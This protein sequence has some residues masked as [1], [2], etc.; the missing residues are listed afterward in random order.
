VTFSDKRVVDLVSER[1]IPVWE[2]VAPVSV[3]VFDL[4]DGRTVK[5]TMGGE[6][7]LYFCRPDGKVFDILPALHSPHVT[8]WA[9]KNALEFYDKTGATDEAIRAHHAQ[10]FAEAS[11]SGWGYDSSGYKEHVEKRRSKEKSS[12]GGTKALGEMALSKSGIVSGSEPITVVEPGGL[13]LY[14]RAV[15]EALKEGAPRIPREWKDHVFVTVLQ[16]E[17]KGGEFEYNV[18]TLAPISIIED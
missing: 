6:I 13:E 1:M 17:L 3:A 5:G 18:D 7:A 14:K 15:H 8:Y 10:R 2:S 11:A 12:D 16:Q 4:G 9:V